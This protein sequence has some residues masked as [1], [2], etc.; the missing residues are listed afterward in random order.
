MKIKELCNKV[1]IEIDKRRKLIVFLSMIFTLLFALY[2]RIVGIINKSLW[3][4]SIS[5]YYFALVFIKSII[6]LYIQKS[7]KRKHDKLIFKLTK[8]LLIILNVL[9]IVPIVLLIKNKRV[10]KMSLILSIAIALYVIIKTI[11]VIINFIKKRKKIDILFKQLRLID[12]IDVV[13]SVLTLQ[14]TLIA[15]NSDGLDLGMY[16]LTIASSIVGMLIN[17]MFTLKLNYNQ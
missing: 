15:V 7:R 1:K 14:N 6:V 5:I 4:E 2:N 3:H 9:L 11:K 13:V 16:Y 10:V 12:L 17:M 8:F